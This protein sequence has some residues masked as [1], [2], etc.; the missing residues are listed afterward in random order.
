MAFLLRS[1]EMALELTHSSFASAGADRDRSVR[2]PGS[3]PRSYS[4]A[5][6]TS[7]LTII[8]NWRQRI[9]TLV[10]QS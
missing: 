4:S 10:G 9:A 1:C 3:R 5:C 6:P 8:L 2:S 7:Q